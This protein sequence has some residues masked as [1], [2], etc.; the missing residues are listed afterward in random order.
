MIDSL[1]KWYNIPKQDSFEFAFKSF[2]LKSFSYNLE[3]KEDKFIKL[4][5]DSIPRSLKDH[6][7]AVYLFTKDTL[8]LSDYSK[9]NKFKSDNFHIKMEGDEITSTRNSRVVIKSIH[10]KIS[11]ESID[12]IKGFFYKQNDTLKLPTFEFYAKAQQ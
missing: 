9:T 4:E 1:S 10:T 2:N 8:K 5:F 12:K 7:L 3:E 6:Q 11:T